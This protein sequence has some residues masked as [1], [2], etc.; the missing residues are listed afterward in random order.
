MR[1]RLMGNILRRPLV[2]IALG[3]T[4]F[5]IAAVAS[6]GLL[7]DRLREALAGVRGAD[8]RWLWVAALAAMHAC[9]G[10]AWSVALRA[11]GSR[12][13]HTAAVVRYGVGSGVNAVAPANLGGVVRLGLLGEDRG[14][15]RRSARRRRGSA[16]EHGARCADGSA[17]SL[18]G[19]AGGDPAVAAVAGCARRLRRRSD[20]RALPAGAHAGRGMH[21]VAGFRSLRHD[22]H[23]TAGVTI[24]MSLALVLKVAAAASVCAALGIERPIVCALLVVPAVEI[25]CVL[26]LTPGN[27]GI[28]SAAVALVLHAQGVTTETAVSAGVAFGALEILAGVTAGVLA[29]MV[30]AAPVLRPRVRPLALT[31]SAAA[32]VM[33][34]GLLVW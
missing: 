9:G 14:R 7:G 30:L 1:L 6:P 13:G 19:G 29:G 16:R 33:A 3:A 11:C 23:S 15:P 5:A 18:R 8:A 28:G 4:A 32:L 22:P 2:L 25:A 21:L 12:H 31:A 26:Q 27:A 10:L 17:R 20:R 34:V 24:A